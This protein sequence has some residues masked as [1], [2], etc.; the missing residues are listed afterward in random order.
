MILALLV[1][2]LPNSNVLWFREWQTSAPPSAPAPLTCLEI[3]LCGFCHSFG[4]RGHMVLEP[5]WF[6]AWLC[7]F[8]QCDLYRS[9]SFLIFSFFVNSGSWTSPKL[10]L[11]SSPKI[12]QNDSTLQRETLSSSL[13]SVKWIL[14][15]L[16]QSCARHWGFKNE[17]RKPLLSS[18]S[19]SSRETHMSTDNSNTMR[20]FW[21]PRDEGLLPWLL[22][23]SYHG[24]WE[25]CRK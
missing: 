18:H 24:K 11:T 22:V 16:F 3:V 9:F 1:G 14:I 4:W 13:L 25:R 21:S 6:Q 2:C 20:G 10:D 7:H 12:L 15:L 17:K 19:E 5:P 23:T 8:H